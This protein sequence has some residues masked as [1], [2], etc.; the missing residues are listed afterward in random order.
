MVT[1]IEQEKVE[2]GAAVK[3][4]GSD[5]TGMAEIR[6][7]FARRLLF[8]FDNANNSEIGRRLETNHA[9]VHPYTN[10]SRLPTS[11]LLLRIHRATGVNIHWLLTGKGPRR[12]E[13]SNA[14]TE[15]EEAEIR[16][17]AQ[18]R[19]KSFD[20]MVKQLAVAALD[21]NRQIES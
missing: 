10:G 16:A 13:G 9:T 19:G 3:T 4:D 20:E 6:K 8:V 5:T 11:E 14:F 18:R 15:T 17:L 7:E 2:S 12:V 1:G 21:L